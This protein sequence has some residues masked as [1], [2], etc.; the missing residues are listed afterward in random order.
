MRIITRDITMTP[1]NEIDMYTSMIWTDRYSTV[2]DFEICVPCTTA[3]KEL[4]DK[5]SFLTIDK[6]DRVMVIE[7]RQVKTKVDRADEYIISGRSAESLLDRRVIMGTMTFGIAPHDEETNETAS[8]NYAV[9]DYLVWYGALCRVIKAMNGGDRIILYRPEK[10]N[11]FEATIVAAGPDEEAALT[12]PIEDIVKAMLNATILNPTDPTR[13]FTNPKW[14]YVESTDNRIKE[15]KMA[16]SFGN[17]NLYDAISSL[18]AGSGL[19]CKVVW[20]EDTETMDFSLFMGVDHSVA[21]SENMVINFKTSLDNLVSTDFITD[22]AGYKTCAY[23]IGAED[24]K[25]TRTISVADEYGRVSNYEY[26]NPNYRTTW[27][28]QVSLS[29]TGMSYNRREVMVDASDIDRYQTVNTNYGR[30]ANDVPVTEVDYRAMLRTRGRTELMNMYSTYDLTAEILPDMFYKY[31]VDYTLGDT[32]SIED[33]FGNT[34]NASVTELIF[35]QDA[36]G[37]KAYPTIETIGAVDGMDQLVSIFVNNP[38]HVNTSKKLIIPDIRSELEDLRSKTYIAYYVAD[39]IDYLLAEHLIYA[40]GTRVVV[41][42]LNDMDTMV[43]GGSITDIYM[44]PENYSMVNTRALQFVK[45]MKDNQFKI[46]ATQIIIPPYDDL[47]AA[48]Q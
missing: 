35:S 32:I 2:G 46:N 16:A 14:R 42:S 26:D 48:I 28:Q 47:P 27:C 9:G 18:L 36:S 34:I 10:G 12:E 38:I 33:R 44:H 19:S 15:I 45:F 23:V 29:G 17:V 7:K 31:M 24:D 4:F 30:T 1:L 25:K 43:L 13:K 37:Y 6:S 21:Q 20:N 41:P 3:N 5:S 11:L 8:Q 40:S 22:D 39:I